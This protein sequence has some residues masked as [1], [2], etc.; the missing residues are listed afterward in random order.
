MPRLNP[1]TLALVMIAAAALALTLTAATGALVPGEIRLAREVQSASGGHRLDAVGD[2]LAL[3]LVEAIVVLVAA[4]IAAVR[5]NAPLALAAIFAA[6]A[7]ALNPELKLLIARARP[8]A[9]DVRVTEFP[10]GMGFPSGHTLA[11]T[12][13]Y[14]Y[15][16]VVAWRVLP[17][18]AALA[19]TLP[20]ACAIALIGFERIYSGAHWPSDVAGGFTIGIL[21]LAAAV[22]LSR[23]A[24]RAWK[25]AGRPPA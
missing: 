2:F 18:W 17:R 22:A 10:G 7:I 1:P 24:T 19:A 6:A 25:R 14:G 16:G 20:A 4:L 13:L 12:L 3:P 8:T 5:R 11:A 15:A 9:A 21:L 23:A